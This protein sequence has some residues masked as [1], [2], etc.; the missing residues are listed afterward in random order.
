MNLCPDSALSRLSM[1]KFVDQI[2]GRLGARIKYKKMSLTK[3][4][5]ASMH[6]HNITN[7]LVT[8]EPTLKINMADNT[9]VAKQLMT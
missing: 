4:E 2:L 5:P 8:N 7:V 3:T 9:D 6:A 1:R